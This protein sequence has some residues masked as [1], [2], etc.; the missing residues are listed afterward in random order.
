MLRR[1]FFSKTT[2]YV[3][4]ICSILMFVMCIIYNPASNPLGQYDFFDIAV[5][6]AL[7][8]LLCWAYMKLNL[9]ALQAGCTAL[10]IALA[11]YQA[12]YVLE[13]LMSLQTESFIIMGFWGSFFLATELMILIL[14]CIIAINHF[15][16]NVLM[17]QNKLRVSV[18]QAL[19]VI[20]MAFLLLLLFE[21][22]KLPLDAE[23]T[24]YMLFYCIGLIANYV[25]VSCAELVILIDTGIGGA[26]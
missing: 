12:N 24:R 5:R 19:L 4:S 25:L 18:N 9:L 10:L 7:I 26:K 21:I 14:E 2:V 8:L 3:A 6:T 15:V 17:K 11:Y 20:L 23:I 1:V 13:G 16:I 22:S